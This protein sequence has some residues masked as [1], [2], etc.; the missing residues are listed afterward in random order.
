MI[1]LALLC[2]AT[3][4]LVFGVATDRHHRRHLGRW[5]SARRAVL[6]KMLGWPLLAATMALATATWGVIM[7]PIAGMGVMMMGAAASFV[8]LNAL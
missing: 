7:G 3:G 1:G 8:I 4:F 5:Y 2:S 6:L